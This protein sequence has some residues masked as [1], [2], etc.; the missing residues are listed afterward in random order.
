MKLSPLP[1]LLG[2]PSPRVIPPVNPA[3]RGTPATH[4]PIFG[5]TL[6]RFPRCSVAGTGGTQLQ[7]SE[8]KFHR[9]LI[10]TLAPPVTLTWHQQVTP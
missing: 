7:P 1:T 8:K 10:S 6:E 4:S 5:D 2:Q 3:T 9:V